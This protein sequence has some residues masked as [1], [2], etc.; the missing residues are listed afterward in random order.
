[1]E[2]RVGVVPLKSAL[3]L[4]PIEIAGVEWGRGETPTYYIRSCHMSRQS[5]GFAGA[6]VGVSPRDLTACCGLRGLVGRRG[7][8]GLRLPWQWF[9][10][11]LFLERSPVLWPAGEGAPCSLCL[12]LQPQGARGLFFPGSAAA[13]RSLREG[14]GEQPGQDLSRPELEEGE[15]Y[16]ACTQKGVPCEA[17]QL[18]WGNRVQR[19]RKTVRGFDSQLFPAVGQAEAPSSLPLPEFVSSLKGRAP[20]LRI[21]YVITGTLR[22]RVPLAFLP[23]SSLLPPLPSPSLLASP[24]ECT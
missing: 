3:A 5:W 14:G 17:A 11:L 24:G 21:A 23:L 18:L 10:L 15:V 1:M 8:G 4:S 22:V 6:G 19:R 12:S 2:L 7:A 13:S 9:L 20:E 16:Q